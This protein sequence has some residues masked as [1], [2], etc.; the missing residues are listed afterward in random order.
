MKNNSDRWTNECQIKV[1]HIYHSNINTLLQKNKDKTVYLIYKD[2]M[3]KTFTLYLR[4]EWFKEMLI[5]K[6]KKT[7]LLDK[8][9][10]IWGL[11]VD[12][13]SNAI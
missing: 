3:R 9:F 13:W 11:L 7:I 1:I 8:V 12:K 5:F 6:R 2:K 10:N 4:N